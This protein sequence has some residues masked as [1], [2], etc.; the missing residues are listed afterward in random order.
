MFISQNF[1]KDRNIRNK[2]VQLAQF[3]IDNNNF[4]QVIQ[5][6]KYEAFHVVNHSYKTEPYVALLPA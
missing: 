3:N 1:F 5:G 6:R 4:L 2:L